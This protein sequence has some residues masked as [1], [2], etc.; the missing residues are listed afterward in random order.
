[1]RKIL[2]LLPILCLSLA[3]HAAQRTQVT[4]LWQTFYEGT[5]TPKSIIRV[6]ESNGVV[7]GEI[8]VTFRKDGTP[9]VVK[10]EQGG[11]VCDTSVK[12]ENMRGAPPFCGLIVLKDLRRN[13]RGVYTG[14][15]I[16]NPER[17]KTYRAE[18]WLD[19]DGNLKIRGRWSIFRRTFTALPI[20]EEQLKAIFTL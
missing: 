3:A 20:T 16:L 15:T 19:N 12:A 14:G 2:L 18:I 1:M 17:D 4:G 11:V 5:N 7:Y 13:N 9:N 10:N 6:Y 8:V